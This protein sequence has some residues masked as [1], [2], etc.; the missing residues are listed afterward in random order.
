MSNSIDADN[1]PA[2]WEIK[3]SQ[4]EEAQYRSRRWHVVCPSGMPLAA[5]AEGA[6][7]RKIADRLTVYDRVECVAFDHSYYAELLVVE[8]APGAALL[9]LLHKV[10]WPREVQVDDGI[11]GHLMVFWMGD[12]QRGCYRIKNLETGQVLPGNYASRAAAR[13]AANEQFPHRAPGAAA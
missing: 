8:S 9:K 2:A 5:L 11:P 3:S 7:W 4:I 1:F 6:A 10:E 13:I 12:R